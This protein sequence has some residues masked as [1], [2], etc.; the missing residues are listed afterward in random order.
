MYHKV[1]GCKVK[2]LLQDVL[3]FTQKTIFPHLPNAE[4]P[5]PL[6]GHVIRL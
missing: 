6:L 1:H 5:V 2:P 4:D 3:I